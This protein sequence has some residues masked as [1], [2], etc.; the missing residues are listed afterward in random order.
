VVYACV[1]SDMPDRATAL[2][3][4]IGSI[5]DVLLLVDYDLELIRLLEEREKEYFI[6]TREIC[7]FYFH[8]TGSK[9]IAEKVWKMCNGDEPADTPELDVLDK[10]RYVKRHC[11]TEMLGL[12]NTSECDVDF[13]PLAVFSFSFLDCANAILKL[14]SDNL[15]M[16]KKF[17]VG[18]RKTLFAPNVLHKMERNMAA[19]NGPA[20]TAGADDAHAVDLESHACTCGWFQELLIPCVHAC[21]AIIGMGGDP[22]MYV[23][24]VYSRA[25]LLELKDVVPVVGLPVKCQSD[26]HLLKRGPGRPRK[27]F[28]REEV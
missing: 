22:F 8:K 25:R 6:K 15:K 20:G 19:V 28:G 7:K 24:S 2:S 17:S 5:E 27:V 11:R 4:F 16:K 1:I 12:Q 3:Y 21:R 23:G 10:R 18:D 9:E 13:I 26:K 14:I